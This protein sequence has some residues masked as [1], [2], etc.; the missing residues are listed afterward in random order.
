MKSAYWPILFVGL[1]QALLL[2]IVLVV[3][4]NLNRPTV[5]PGGSG[6]TKQINEETKVYPTKWKPGSTAALIQFG[7]DY[8][9]QHD[10]KQ[11][12]GGGIDHQ[13]VGRLREDLVRKGMPV[14]S[15]DGVSLVDAAASV[16][17]KTL[18]P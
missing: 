8:C 17:Q 12:R 18:C 6:S 7:Y 15:A 11:R 14:N 10:R 16:A 5:P 4:L 2:T 1:S 9:E 3:V 13:T